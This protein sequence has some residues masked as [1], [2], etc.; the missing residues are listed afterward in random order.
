ARVLG[1]RDRDGAAAAG[2][3][4]DALRPGGAHRAAAR[5]L[6]Q[7]ARSPPP[8]AAQLSRRVA[9][10][11]ARDGGIVTDSDAA[12]R[13]ILRAIRENLKPRGIAPRSAEPVQSTA[14][15]GPAA[16][17]SPPG[18]RP[19]S[20]GPV[21]RASPDAVTRFKA[22]LAA[23]GAQCTLACGEPDA[24]RA[25]AR[26]LTDAGARRVVGSDAA[27]VQRLPSTLGRDFV[28][29]SVDALSRDAVCYSASGR[30]AARR[31]M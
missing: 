15:P 16:R 17:G 18:L 5:C 4:G 30:T 23:I 21:K 14:D 31:G 12:R 8:R 24:A 25:L 6:D 22:Q 19:G 1:L 7:V 10:G 26:I 2:R 20:V 27:L 3:V 11:T 29:G 28:C 13:D 9:G